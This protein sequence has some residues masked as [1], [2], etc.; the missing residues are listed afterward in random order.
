MFNETP[1]D[2]R[3]HFLNHSS[4]FW[5]QYF[6]L[7]SF[8][9]LS[10]STTK[11]EFSSPESSSQS[12]LWLSGDCRRSARPMFWYPTLYSHWLN[13]QINSTPDWTQLIFSQID[14]LRT[15]FQSS[16][17]N[18]NLYSSSTF[19]SMA[20][21]AHIN[22]TVYIIHIHSPLWA[23]LPCY[24]NC[25]A[26]TVVAQSTLGPSRAWRH[27]FEPRLLPVYFDHYGL[28]FPL[29]CISLLSYSVRW[30]VRICDTILSVTNG[31]WPHE[32]G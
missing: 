28:P 20:Q 15:I 29:C 3:K 17:L 4:S 22:I 7:A 9:P 26:S 14:L 31:S 21:L 30:V 24:I 13:N 23:A 11:S 8:G 19:L 25:W 6:C 32:N 16:Y 18:P 10:T 5:Q 27:W 12:G 2:L 1:H